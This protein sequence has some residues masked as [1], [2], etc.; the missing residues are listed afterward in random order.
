MNPDPKHVEAV[1]ASALGQAPPGRAAFLDR[2]CAG[3]TPL[4]RRVEALLQAHDRA[5]S[6]LEKPAPAG[7]AEAPTAGP[8]DVL[9][10]EPVPGTRVRYVGDYE[11]L[12]EIARGGMGVVY[13]ARQVSLNRVVALKMILAGQLASVDDVQRF[14]TEAEAVANLDHPNIVPVYEVGEHEGQHYFSMKL[15]E[16]CNLAR[17]LAAGPAPDPR[18]LVTLLEDVAR[19]VHF[20]HQRGILHRDLKPANV[21][22]DEDGRPYV[23]DFGLA[24]RV[25]Q[26]RGLT[27]SGAIVGTPGYLA[28]E[29]A[30]GDRG[31]SV[32]ADVYSLGAIL[33]EVLTG[34]PPFQAETPLDTLL[35]TLEREP[36][37]PRSL[38][39]R[40]DR[41]LETICLKCLEKEPAKRYGSA[42]EVA[43]DLRRWRTSEP[44]RARPVGSWERLLKYARRK[45]ALVALFAALA[46]LLVTT[47]VLV[48][49]GQF[50]AL[51]SLRAERRSSYLQR[52]GSRLICFADRR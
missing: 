3:D 35:A 37:R 13:K 20:A 25:G 16:G 52:I 1:F 32:A 47:F 14:R 29:Q 33:F 15:I 26:A 42:E 45:P 49:L 24:R 23:T 30:R 21:L 9:P 51:Q 18:P 48:S 43:D 38:R 41:D 17:L 39:P 11:L 5:G 44:I 2:A 31:L 10:P 19:A 4:R 27:R 50:Q 6:F 40:V 36:P 12:E 46:A 7:T 22:L 28:P 34:R 8:A